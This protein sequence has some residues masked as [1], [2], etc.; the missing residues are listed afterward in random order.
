[1]VFDMSSDFPSERFDLFCYQQE[2]VRPPVFLYSFGIE[3]DS[4]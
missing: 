3:D 2:R 1:M 4:F